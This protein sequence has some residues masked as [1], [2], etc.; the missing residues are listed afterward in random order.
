[1]KESTKW[2]E[3]LW[4]P[5]VPCKCQ[6]NV[7]SVTS[8]HT[9]S[10]PDIDP[11]VSCCEFSPCTCLTSLPQPSFTHPCL[12]GCSWNRTQATLPFVL[13]FRQNSQRPSIIQWVPNVV[14]PDSECWTIGAVWVRVRNRACHHRPVPHLPFLRVKGS[15]RETG[16]SFVGAG[17][18]HCSRVSPSLSHYCHTTLLRRDVWVSLPPRQANRWH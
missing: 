9:P 17:D 10:L 4:G 13:A 8:T 11:H 18:P 12:S 15:D 16:L 14:H 7:L 6:V 1:M 3:T 5:P 2:N